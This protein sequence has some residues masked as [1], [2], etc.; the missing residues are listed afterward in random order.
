MPAARD[1]PLPR[2]NIDS[3]T[4]P[5]APVS[6]SGRESLPPLMAQFRCG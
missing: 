2:I 4:D 1:K 6:L 5:A 3:A